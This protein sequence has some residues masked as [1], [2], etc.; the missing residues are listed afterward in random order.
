MRTGVASVKID[1]CSNIDGV[2]AEDVERSRGG[3]PDSAPRD[4]F[5]LTVAMLMLDIET[6]GR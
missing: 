3:D 5:R 4:R 6:H 2:L 1:R